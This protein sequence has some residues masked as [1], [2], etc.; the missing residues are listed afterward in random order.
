MMEYDSE[1]L[2]SEEIYS[3]LRGVTEAIQ[4]YSFRSQDDLM[5][6]RRDGKRDATVS[7][8]DST[9][10]SFPD[11]WRSHPSP[12]RQSG[13]GASSDADAVGCGRT[14]LD[15]KTSLLNTPSPRSFAG[16]R[17]RDYNPYNYSDALDKA[18]AKEAF[19]EG[20]GEHLR[21]GEVLVR[22]WSC[23]QNKIT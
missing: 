6:L 16:P 15:N 7:R 2:N 23:F 17:F 14:A 5:E 4:N 10:S 13:V 1:N 18:A 20:G 19:H 11:A 8:K 22:K 3:S 21:D 9:F 12:P